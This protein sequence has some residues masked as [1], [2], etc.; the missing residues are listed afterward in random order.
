MRHINHVG[1]CWHDA[2]DGLFLHD[3]LLRSIGKVAR[4]Y[5]LRPESLDGIHDISRLIKKSLAHIC[6]PLEVLIHPF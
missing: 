6:R 1:F 3:L 5:C 2:N 4:G